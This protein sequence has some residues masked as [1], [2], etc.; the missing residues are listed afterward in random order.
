MCML[1][2]KRDITSAVFVTG[3]PDKELNVELHVHVFND[4]QVRGMSAV[5][6]YIKQ[7]VTDHGKQFKHHIGNEICILG[8]ISEYC[9]RSK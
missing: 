8:C 7:H 9:Q 2:P 3:L 4:I 1:F 6:V 5:R